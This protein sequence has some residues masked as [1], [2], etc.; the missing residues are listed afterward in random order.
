M[1]SFFF[2]LFFVLAFMGCSNVIKQED[3]QQVESGCIS[4]CIEERFDSNGNVIYKK[5]NDGYEVIAEY[6]ERNNC[7]YENY[8]GRYIKKTAYDSYNRK[9]HE[10]Y[11][12][13]GAEYWYE[14]TTFENG[15]L[16][17][18]VIKSNSGY[19]ETREYDI[20]GKGIH[21]YD[22]FGYEAWEEYY[23]DGTRKK[24]FDTEGRIVLYNE[25]GYIIYD[26]KETGL[27]IVCDYDKNYNYTHYKCSDGYERWEEVDSEGNIIYF[28]DSEGN[29][30]LDEYLEK[31]K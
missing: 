31:L 29:N 17:T 23:P 28:K 7:I 24:V 22:N 12:T 16:K 10:I 13:S 15:S 18:K 19:I 8:F 26:K 3:C 20:F 27:E 2:V 1:K 21:W 4:V 30:S 11:V 9:V 6:D 5:Y 25:D 14:Y